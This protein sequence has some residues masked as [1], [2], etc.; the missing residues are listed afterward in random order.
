MNS[1]EMFVLVQNKH[2][3]GGMAREKNRILLISNAVSG[4]SPLHSNPLTVH[5]LVNISRNIDAI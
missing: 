2:R 4:K 5:S 1:V 3:K